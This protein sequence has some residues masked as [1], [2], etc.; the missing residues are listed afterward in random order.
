ME[1]QRLSDLTR[2]LES[3]RRV[4]ST[5]RAMLAYADSHR[6]LHQALGLVKNDQGAL[7]MLQRAAVSPHSMSTT[8]TFVQNVVDAVVD[9]LGPDNAASAVFSRAGVKVQF[10]V[11]GS[12]W[13]PG[14]SADGSKASWVSQG[15]PVRVGQWDS[16]KG[17]TLSSGLRMSYAVAVTSEMLAYSSAE[18]II[19][20][21]LAED[22]GA[23][24]EASLFGNAAAVANQSPA[25]LLKDA[26]TVNA[27]TS[28]VPGDA[29]IADLG[30]LAAAV[31]ATGGEIL[32]IGN[33][34]EVT[35]V[36][37]RLPFLPNVFPSGAVTTGNLIA[38]APRGIAVGGSDQGPRI[39]TA[40]EATLWMDDAATNQQLSASGSPNTIVAPIRSL[41]Q[42]DSAALRL[43][44][45]DLCWG[46]RIAAGTGGCVAALTGTLKW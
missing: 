3:E 23:G 45:P 4:R 25:G 18:G 37:A 9:I 36:K 7:A 42:T 27:S 46:Q 11:N 22:V 35:R 26:Q 15:N 17:C 30:G 24:L 44:L 31:G 41:F 19:R 20:R 40:K 2:H 8:T 32:F 14:V 13:V 29:L 21:K 38:I 1:P 39:D 5:C 43:V 16:S 6:N 10:G 34:A 12:V 33:I 28:T